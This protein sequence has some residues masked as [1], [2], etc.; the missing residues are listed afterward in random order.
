MIL[1]T[2]A[3]GFIGTSLL[4]RLRDLGEPVI[5][6]HRAAGA[7]AFTDKWECDLTR[8][9]DLMILSS[10]STAPD[11]I[12]HLAGYVEISLRE[13]PQ[14]RE[15]PPLPGPEDVSQTY[16]CNVGATANLLDYCLKAGV[17]RLIF[18]SS[19]SVYGMPQ[20]TPLTEETP[21]VPLEH[22]ALSK[23]CCEQ[24]LRIGAQQGLAVTVLRIPG[25]F[26]EKRQRGLVFE[27]CRQAIQEKEIRVTTEF[28]VPLDVLH[29]DDAIEAFVKAVR[30]EPP[31]WTCMNI[32]TGAACS[33]DL[34]ADEIAALVPGCRVKHGQ[35]SQPVV[36]MDPTRAETMLGWKAVPRSVRLTSMLEGIGHAN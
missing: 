13:N 16:A 36:Q 35:V 3:Q 22:Y 20:S 24:M 8:R 31:D 33:V 4:S 30:Y 17:R 23:L 29:L 14:A 21:C 10:I 9:D 11:T 28:P 18:A 6:L 7:R 27:F 25:I 1:L 34:L 2:G 12:I 26:S 32:S 5:P 15:A 19:Q